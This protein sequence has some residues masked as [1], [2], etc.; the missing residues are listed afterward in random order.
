MAHTERNVLLKKLNKAKTQ[1]KIGAKYQHTKSGGKY[2]VTGLVI[3]ED[4]GEIRVIYKELSH[5]PSITWDRSFD[6]QGGWIVPVEIEGK[7][8]ARFTKISS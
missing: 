8:V 2:I 1:I 3:R 5:K 4:N 6:G 7:P